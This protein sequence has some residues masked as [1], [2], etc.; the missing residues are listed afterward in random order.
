MREGLPAQLFG[1]LR[2][3]LRQRGGGGCHRL[4]SELLLSGRYAS[5]DEVDGVPDCLDLGR[6]LLAHPD[7]VAVLELHDELVEVE[8]IGV[9]ILTEPG[10][11]LDPLGSHLE[12]GAEVVP[13]ELHDLVA[14]HRGHY[15]LST[16]CPRRGLAQGITRRT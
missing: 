14:L 11:R 3:Q 12:L 5:G 16:A 1:G 7:P 2:E 8:R 10:V 4:W 6:L 13:D 9:E 15:R